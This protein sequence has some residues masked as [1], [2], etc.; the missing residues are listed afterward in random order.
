MPETKRKPRSQPAWTD[1]KARLAGF[2]RRGL[3]GLIQD[4]YA[5]HKENRTFL[6][7]RFGAFFAYLTF[8]NRWLETR[9]MERN[10]LANLHFRTLLGHQREPLGWSALYWRSPRVVPELSKRLQIRAPNFKPSFRGPVCE[11][12]ASRIRVR[13]GDIKDGSRPYNGRPSGRRQRRR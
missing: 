2:D 6:H 13:S 10:S 1:I 3:M 5:A 4:L 11:G 7:A 9:Y 8:I 12:H